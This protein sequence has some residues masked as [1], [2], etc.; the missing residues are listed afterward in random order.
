[1]KDSIKKRIASLQPGDELI[2]DDV[3]YN[4]SS[5]YRQIVSAINAGRTEKLSL[6]YDSDTKTVSVFFRG[7][8]KASTIEQ[9]YEG[10][11]EFSLGLRRL[12]ARTGIS[13]ERY[14]RIEN[15]VLHLLNLMKVSIVD[16]E[17][18]TDEELVPQKPT[19]EEL[20]ENHKLAN[21]HL[22]TWTLNNQAALT[23]DRI[24]KLP[25]EH[26]LT[27]EQIG[28]FVTDE[29]TYAITKY[30]RSV[31]INPAGAY[32]EKPTLVDD[33]E[34]LPPIPTKMIDDDEIRF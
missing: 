10:I 24:M 9:E 15:E 4:K 16:K 21:T 6:T 28:P 25:M 19:K 34:A 3:D 13:K 18:R 31:G 32:L 11:K 5:Y 8:A 30:M 2:L 14:I 20:R 27:I 1:M 17:D 29:H 7:Y 33:E 23:H 22:V 12:K 26:Q